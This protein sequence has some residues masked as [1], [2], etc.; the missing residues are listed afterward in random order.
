MVRAFRFLRRVASLALA[1]A[2][3]HAGA[4]AITLQASGSTIALGSTFSVAIVADIPQA[5]EIIGFGF[6]LVA[7]GNLSFLGFTAG[8]G[9]ADDPTYLAPFSDGDGIR[10]AADGDLLTGGPVSGTGIVLGM[11][12]FRADGLGFASVSLSA[13]DLAGNFT[14][15]L[16]PLSLGLFNFMPPVTAADVEV[17][18]A[19]LAEPAAAIATVLAGW[20]LASIRRRRAGGTARL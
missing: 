14:E 13:D 10:G 20:W 1:L 7:P 16:I 4:A 19:E 15:G 18:A 17:Q 11:L 2:A 8:P 12:H 9:F 6:D 5:E 3:T